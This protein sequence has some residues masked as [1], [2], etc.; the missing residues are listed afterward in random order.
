[1]KL[2]DGQY[3]DGRRVLLISNYYLCRILFKKSL[4]C[5]NIPPC[6]TLLQMCNTTVTPK[7]RINKP[8]VTLV[9]LVTLF[10]IYYIYFYLYRVI[11]YLLKLYKNIKFNC[12]ILNIPIPMRFYL[13]QNLLHI[14]YICYT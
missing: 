7:N 10:S 2:S 3:K 8:F 1:M 4:T 5:N 6:S 14:C 13:E 9:T 11:Y 12:H